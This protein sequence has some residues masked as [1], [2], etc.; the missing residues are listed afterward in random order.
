M[1]YNSL[2]ET[3][4]PYLVLVVTCAG[5]LDT[6][7]LKLGTCTRGFSKVPRGTAYWVSVRM[8]ESTRMKKRHRNSIVQA[9]VHRYERCSER[10]IGV[11]V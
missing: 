4:K 8:I 11:I 5:S 2:L 3:V 6:S 10:W 1:T 9:D 7:R